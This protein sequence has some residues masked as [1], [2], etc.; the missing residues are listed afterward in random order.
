VGLF[1][2]ADNARN[3]QAKLTAA[4]IT[5][6]TEELDTVRGKRTRVRVGPFDSKAAAKTVAGKIQA[7]K[8]EAVVFRQ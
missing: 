1:A 8:L 3:A 4:G 7:L 6:F 5:P 2:E